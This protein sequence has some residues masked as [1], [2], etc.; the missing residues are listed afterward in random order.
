[1]PKVLRWKSGASDLST[2]ANKFSSKWSRGN[3]SSSAPSHSSHHEGD[4]PT[5]RRLTASEVENKNASRGDKRVSFGF[6][7]KESELIHREK[8]DEIKDL[9][10]EE[11]NIDIAS[12]ILKVERAD[13]AVPV[14]DDAQPESMADESA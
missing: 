7:D 9:I 13:E 2:T 3:N 10:M 14:A 11:H 8:L 1:V 5:I 4:I 6:G 12:I